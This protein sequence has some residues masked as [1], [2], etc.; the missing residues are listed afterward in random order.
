MQGY[1]IS[2]PCIKASA[3][4]PAYSSALYQI[5]SARAGLFG[6]LGRQVRIRGSEA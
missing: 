3:G 5:K 1:E 4:S 2:H 6:P